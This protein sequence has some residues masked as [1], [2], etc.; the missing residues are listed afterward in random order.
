MPESLSSDVKAPVKTTADDV[1]DLLNMDDETPEPKDDDK[2]EP[3]S[4]T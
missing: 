4:K 3:K 1:V 2:P